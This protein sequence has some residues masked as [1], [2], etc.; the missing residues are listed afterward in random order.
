MKCVIC[1]TGALTPG[2]TTVTLS[3]GEST[4]VIKGVPADLCDNCA[5]YYLVED[6]ARRVYAVADDAVKAGAEVQIVRYAA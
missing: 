5:E 3:R 4:V 6:I 2:R 1:R